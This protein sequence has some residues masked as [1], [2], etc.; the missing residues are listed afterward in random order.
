MFPDLPSARTVICH[1]RRRPAK[2]VRRSTGPRRLFLAVAMLA[3][4]VSVV[5]PGSA[6]GAAAPRA[7]TV[8]YWLEAHD[9]GVFAFGGAPFLGSAIQRCTF[10]CFGFGATPDG[11]GYWVVDS[12]PADP[13][14]GQLYGYGTG[15][16]IQAHDLLNDGA[17]GVASTPSGNGGWLMYG[18]SGLVVPF[19][20][21][22]WYGDASRLG[23]SEVTLPPYGSAIP[24]FQGIVATPDGGGYWLV[25][26]DGGVFAYGDATYDG[27]MGGQRLNAPISGLASTPDGHGYWLV[28][29][30]GG[31]FSF[32]DAAFYGS[33]GG[34]PLNDIVIGIAADPD[35]GGYWM[36]A[37]DGG[38]FAFGDAPFLGSMGASRLAQPISAIAAAL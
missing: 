15:S 10:E 23:R 37:M 17:T 31:V 28:A 21:A 12:F 35:G 1:D 20:D 2:R 13:S 24:Y 7:A 32:G 34:K 29:Y 38:V 4:C 30:D 19:G 18:S 14:A 5:A 3:V 11:H 36:A 8:G 26:L 33:M 22:N 6:A 16:G 25:G 27:S 9:G